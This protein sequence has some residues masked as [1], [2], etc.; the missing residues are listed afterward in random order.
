MFNDDAPSGIPNPTRRANHVDAFD[1]TGGTGRN[2][3]TDATHAE[4]TG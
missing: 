1:D 2:I 4:H 3:T